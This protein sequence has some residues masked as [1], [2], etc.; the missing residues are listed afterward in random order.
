MAGYTDRITLDFHV[1]N[2]AGRPATDEFLSGVQYICSTLTRD[3]P[4]EWVEFDGVLNPLRNDGEQVHGTMA[5]QLV[6]SNVGSS[7][8]TEILFCNHRFFFQQ[9]VPVKKQLNF[10]APIFLT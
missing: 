6:E 9:R 8:L 4:P 2:A 3:K 7:K 5:L 10:S 1:L